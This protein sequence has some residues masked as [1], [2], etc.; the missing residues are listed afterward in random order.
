MLAIS[1]VQR[2]RPRPI[3]TNMKRREYAPNRIR[4]VRQSRKISQ[5]ELGGAM[6][7]QLTG[8]TIAKL[9]NGRQAV[10]IDYLTD[11]ARILEV[12]VS[13]LLAGGNASTRSL[14]VIGL[15]AAGQWQEAVEVTDETI[16]VPGHLEGKDLFVLRPEGDSM[17]LLVP[18]WSE[19]G[20]IVVDP[21]Q[22]DLVDKKYYV[23]ENG[24]KTTTFKQFCADPLSLLPCST[25]P[26]H[27][28]IP[29]GAEAFRVIGRVVYVGRDV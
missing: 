7:A 23:V 17:D 12:E 14:P 11:I 22:T 10:S 6:D 19:G 28:P 21:A 4:E 27:E 15:V 24:D 9:E 2:Y 3:S 29:L 18:S 13:A 20:Y 16:P 5:E 1:D 8:S 26:M 25:N